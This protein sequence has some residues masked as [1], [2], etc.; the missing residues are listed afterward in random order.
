MDYYNILGVNKNANDEDIKKA[1]RKLA[2]KYHPDKAPED[3]KDEY[4]KKFQEIS[5]ANEI[6]SNSEKRQ[7]YDAQGL[8]G[9]KNNQRGPTA[10]DIFK[11]MFR[12]FHDPVR[13][14]QIRKNQDTVHQIQLTLKD[15]YTGIIKKIKITRKIIF[16]KS[17]KVQVTENLETTWEFCKECNGQGVTLKVMQNGPFIQQMQEIC[18]KCTG[19]GST[20]LEDYEIRENSEIIQLNI[21]KGTNNGDHLRFERQGNCAAGVIPGDIVFVF[22]VNLS[23]DNFTRNGNN[24][25]YKVSIN[26]VDA[27]CGGKIKI[28]MLDDKVLEYPYECVNMKDGVTEKKIIPNLGVAGGNLIINFLIS[29]PMLDKKQKEEIRKILG[30]V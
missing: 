4:T 8:D 3:K 15:V 13:V 7:I 28:K 22:Q 25:E 21:Q 2:I 20:L 29:F 26:M 12:G 5:E 30:T 11:D 16:Q 27:L 9:L 19:T 14:N 23:Y 10:A 1:Y 18:N 24:L 6:L 17:K